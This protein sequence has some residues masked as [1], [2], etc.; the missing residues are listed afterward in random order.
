[1]NT[2]GSGPFR[3]YADRYLNYALVGTDVICDTVMAISD[4]PNKEWHDMSQ[5]SIKL[6]RVTNDNLPELRYVVQASMERMLEFKSV[7][8][9]KDV[10]LT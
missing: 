4:D 8:D 1:M 6:H 10:I 9:R 2:I 7:L 5:F 3:V